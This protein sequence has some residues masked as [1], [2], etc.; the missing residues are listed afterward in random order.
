MSRWDLTRDWKVRV[1]PIPRDGNCLYSSLCHQLYGCDVSSTI[2]RNAITNLRNAVVDFVWEWRQMLKI[3]HAVITR[4]DEEW[5][6]LSSA[7]YE[8]KVT[9]LLEYLR[10]NGHWGE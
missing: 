5:P 2:H 7:H 4:V 9:Q 10:V 1:Q 3:R 8:D 6:R